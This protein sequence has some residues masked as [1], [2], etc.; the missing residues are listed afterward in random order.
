LI[1]SRPNQ[2]ALEASDHCATDIGFCVVTDNC[3][4][5]PVA[6]EAATGPLRWCKKFIARDRNPNPLQCI[7]QLT[8]SGASYWL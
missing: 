8:A 4:F 3:G 1:F 2:D 6:S 5:A 7:E